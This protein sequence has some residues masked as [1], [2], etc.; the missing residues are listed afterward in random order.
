M[1]DRLTSMAVFCRVASKGSFAAAAEGLGMTSAMV[2]K[3]I[4]SLEDRLGA[5]LI[6]R[7]TRRQSLTDAGRSFLHKAR[8]ILAEVELAEGLLDG[9]RSAP[10]GKLRVTAPASFGETLSPALVEYSSLFPEVFIDLFLSNKVVDLV[11]E[12]IDVAFRTGRLA[13]SGLITRS[14][15]P[16]HFVLCAAPSYIDR[17]GSP[18]TPQDLENHRCLTFAGW[19]DGSPWTF[20]TQR[21]V[22]CE[23]HVK[24]HMRINDRAAL[25][26]AAIAGGG[27]IFQSRP[28]IAGA[29]EDG[30]LIRLLPD[31][32]PPPKPLH[33]VW[34]SDRHPTLKLRSFIDFSVAQFG[35][36]PRAI[37]QA[38]GT[39]SKSVRGNASAI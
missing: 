31:W 14:L 1:L 39:P 8:S 35:K 29:I 9:A 24:S 6:S 32:E 33:L 37:R 30:R 38:M 13:A 27:I 12:G 19:M 2:G 4:R 16:Y 10:H 22:E 17:F 5:A 18:K 15:A 20:S 11:G 23:V 7:T 28:S 21:G 25:R 34:V 3:H 36:V 26:A